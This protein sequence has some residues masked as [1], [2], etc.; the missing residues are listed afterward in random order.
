MPATPYSP[1]DRRPI[2]ARGWRAS[3]FAASRLARNGVSPNAISVAGMFCAIGAGAALASTATEPAWG[4]VAWLAAAA[5]IPLRL[6]ANLL[7][8]M[9]AIESGRASRLGEL[10]N[11]VP[12]RVSDAAVL[13]GLGYAHGSEPALGYLAA[14][15]AVFT[16]YVRAVGKVAGA[17]QFFQGPMAKQHRMWLV[18]TFCLCAALAPGT[19]ATR[20]PDGWLATPS[21]L[22]ILIVLGCVVTTARRL[23]LIRNALRGPTR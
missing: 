9:V 13:I 23:N 21:W 10:F 8:G 6:V 12:D 15:L 7:D 4:R 17:P 14:L 2:G 3:R 16:A 18:T 22:L 5:L 11:E 19:P 20:L 1:T